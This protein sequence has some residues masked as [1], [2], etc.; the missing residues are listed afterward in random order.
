MK[1]KIHLVP[2]THETPSIITS[3]IAFRKNYEK[4]KEDDKRISRN[5]ISYLNSLFNSLEDEDIDVIFHEG[6]FKN[7]RLIELI[8]V[9][10]P[11]QKRILKFAFNKKSRIEKT[12]K[13]AHWI[14]HA[15]VSN[16]SLFLKVYFPK[17][18]NNYLVDKII[19]KSK[20]IF[21]RKRD[22]NMAYNVSKRLKESETGILFY[23]KAHHPENY[24]NV[25]SPDIELIFH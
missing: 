7:Y 19:K 6:M 12:E 9:E 14:S 20:K 15:L 2:I 25:L 17:M 11:S 24:V 3:N 13:K 8:D 21:I 1:R 5:L 18:R 22:Y 10:I 23:G 16:L 4:F